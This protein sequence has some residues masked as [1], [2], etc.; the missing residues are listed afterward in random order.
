MYLFILNGY[1][2]IYTVKQENSL[3]QL[4][5]Y[6]I[7]WTTFKSIFFFYKQYYFTIIFILL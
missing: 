2:G 7:Y 3:I 6:Y 5:T 1:S 4:F